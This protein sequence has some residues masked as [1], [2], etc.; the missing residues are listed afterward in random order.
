MTWSAF[1]PSDDA[2]RYGFHVPANALAAVSLARLAAL[3]EASGVSGTARDAATLADE[4]RRGVEAF[5]RVETRSH[6][7]IYAY[8]VDGLGGKLLLDDANVPSL[9]S[10]P[11][12]GYCDRT[13]PTYLA[14]RAWSLGPANPCWGEG[15][16]VSGVGSRHTRRGWVWPLGIAVE[17]L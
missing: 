15:R 4:L 8:E 6:G 10:L 7:F 16:V 2:C 9:V 5:G 1:R 3:L 12:I 14:T 17:G 11:Y 13:D